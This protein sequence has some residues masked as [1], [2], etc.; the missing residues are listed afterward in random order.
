MGR[1]LQ[2]REPKVRVAWL[3][4]DEGDNDPTHFLTYLIAALQTIVTNMG[5]GMLNVL[6]APQPPPIESILTTLLN[7]ITT[8]PDNFILVLDDYHAIDAKSIDSALTFLLEHLPPQIHL[9]IATREIHIYPWP[10][11]VFGIN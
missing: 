2:R 6:Q 5:A 1:R 11:Y 3:S 7:E 8:I 10:G 9:V 4:L